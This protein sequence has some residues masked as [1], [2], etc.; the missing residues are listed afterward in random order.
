M[1]LG[2]GRA[3]LPAILAARELGSRVI[4]VDPDPR[5]PGLPLADCAHAH[6][7]ADVDAILALALTYQIDGVV[8]LAADYP[9]PLLARICA[10]LRLPGPPPPVVERATNKRL[11]RLAFHAAGLG[12]PRFMHVT[13]NAE[14]LHAAVELSADTVFKPAMSH[15]GRGV[16]HVPAGS[17][18]KVVARAFERALRETRADGVMVEEFIDGPEFSVETLSYDGIANVIAVTDKLTTGPPFFVELG[19]SQPSLVAPEWVSLL[20]GTA[21]QALAALGVDHAA[22]H[23][24]IRIGARGPI[25]ME[26]AARLG[27]G[28]ITSHLVPLSTGIDMVA[29]AIRIALGEPPDLL[30]RTMRRAAAVRFLHADPGKI[31]SIAGVDDARKMPGVEHVEVYPA[32]GELVPDLVDARGRIGHVICTSV[33]AREAIC[34]AENAVQMIDI[35]TTSTP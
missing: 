25:V 27:G 23:V 32:Y 19:H 15:G 1:I 17:D 10:E 26:A 16:T 9:M 22:G 31:C 30:P 6:D 11:M 34:R 28:F 24:E 14:A 2:A 20:A 18:P 33:D 13:S 21:V 29:G 3:Q 7:L 5:A 4:A 8:T 35:R 12:N